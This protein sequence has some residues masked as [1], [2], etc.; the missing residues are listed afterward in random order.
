MS[1]KIQPP[2]AQARGSHYRATCRVWLDATQ[3]TRFR[4]VDNHRADRGPTRSLP[5]CQHRRYRFRSR[6]YA[7]ECSSFVGPIGCFVSHGTSP[8]ASGQR[9]RVDRRRRR[10]GVA[11]YRQLSAVGPHLASIS[12]G[13]AYA[14]RGPWLRSRVASTILGPRQFSSSSSVR[15][16]QIAAGFWRARLAMARELYRYA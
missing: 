1:S 8:Q 2:S 11:P 16:G 10:R 7:S 12:L 6:H 9:D 5:S 4:S 13:R 14:D 3:P 15:P